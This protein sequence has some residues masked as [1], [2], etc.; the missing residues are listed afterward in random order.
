MR[1]LAIQPDGGICVNYVAVK[2]KK[3]KKNR[4]SEKASTVN[5]CTR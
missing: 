3:R 5:A 1:E 4:V 2:K